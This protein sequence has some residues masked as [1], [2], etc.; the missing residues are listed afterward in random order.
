MNAEHLFLLGINTRTLLTKT[1]PSENKSELNSFNHRTAT[2]I[3]VIRSG[4]SSSV[5]GGNNNIASGVY[6][7]VLG[8]DQKAA[9]ADY[10]TFPAYIVTV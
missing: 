7:A 2:I 5:T 6:S 3:K 9:V 8:G 4:Q 1:T 10:E